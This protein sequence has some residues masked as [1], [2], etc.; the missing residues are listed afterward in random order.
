MSKKKA[1]YL[2]TLVNGS[3][4]FDYKVEIDSVEQTIISN[5][6]FIQYVEDMLSERLYFTTFDESLSVET[7]VAK[8]KENLLRA[9]A[10]FK[11]QMSENKRFAWLALHTDYNPIENYDRYEEGGYTDEHHKG[12]RTSTNTDLTT[13]PNL[14]TEVTSRTKVKTSNYNYG[15]DSDSASPTNYTET[16]PTE[17][18]DK[19]TQTG[20]NT[21]TGDAS[22]NYT[23]VRDIS[24]SVFDKDIHTVDGSHIHGNI[25]VAKTSEI[26][27]DELKMREY[28][29][30]VHTIEEFVNM[31][32]CYID[33][34]EV[35]A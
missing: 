35:V 34:V 4:S 11:D 5:G 20:T 23:E 3:R 1:Y 22:T 29:L 21:T 26:I 30:A 16:E 13:T 17:G 33:G 31:Y 18:T 6:Q 8:A 25:G 7:N 12:S 14:T 32:T 28:N 15:F 10:S 19:T 24:E 2:S 27:A 9:W